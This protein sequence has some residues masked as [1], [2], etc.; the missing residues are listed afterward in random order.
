M[1]RQ[2][3]VLIVPA[4]ELPDGLHK[5]PR[6]GGRVVLALGEATGHAHAI[7]DRGATLYSDDPIAKREGNVVYLRITR[8]VALRHE[9][10]A[11]IHLDPGVY[12]VVRQREWTDD[13]EPIRVAD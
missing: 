11:P 7:A 12:R 3:D 6:E 8:P 4:N 2:G 9:E 13:E 10:H 5:L 1:F